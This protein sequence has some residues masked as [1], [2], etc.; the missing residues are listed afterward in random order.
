MA[1]MVKFNQFVE[2][3]VKGVHDLS[4]D[5]ILLAFCTEANAPE[6]ADSVLADLTTVATTNLADATLTVS[7][8]DQTDGT[9][10]V[11]VADKTLAASGGTFGPFRYIVVYNDTPTSPADP[12]IGFYDVGFDITLLDTEEQPLDF[13]DTLGMFTIV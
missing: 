11:I 3:L 1:S 4:S 5:T 12:L 8:A 10:A 6:A 13:N 2:D 9:V 7:S